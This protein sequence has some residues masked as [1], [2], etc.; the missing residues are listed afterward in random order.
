MAQGTFETSL[1]LNFTEAE[2]N[3]RGPV[4]L[5]NTPDQLPDPIDLADLPESILQSSAMEAVI[6]QNEDL[7]ARLTVSLRRISFLEE[8]VKESTAESQTYKD[9]HENL[10]DQILIL[11]EQTK[12]LTHK[13]A[14]VANER[15][16]RDQEIAELKEQIRVLEVRY[17]E[18]FQTN[19]SAKQKFDDELTSYE[20]IVNRFRKYRQNIKITLPKFRREFDALKSRLTQQEALVAGL[21]Q[22]LNETTEYITEQGQNHKR[23]IRDLTESFEAKIKDLNGENEM[24]M[25]QNRVLGERLKEFDRLQTD[26]YRLENELVVANRRE[27]ES[28]EQF[29]TELHETQ[30]LL[31]KYRSESKQLAVELQEK[32]SQIEDY[33][34][35]NDHL[36]ETQEALNEQVESLQALW[37]E[38]QAKVEN[39]TEQKAS[40]QRL[41]QELSVACNKQRIEIRELNE[42]LSRSSV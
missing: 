37:S 26:R 13:N 11:K 5:P 21:R 42:K 40:L 36:R 35:Q 17:A 34:K 16:R 12:R 29:E 39:L 22:N 33:K 28:R 14:G 9:R 4:S 27:Q 8:K 19:R 32:I 30:A 18:L 41:N 38:K 20:K 15:A 7:M 10:K 6:Q 25:E 23:E 31:G 2:I 3:G 24:L 1:D